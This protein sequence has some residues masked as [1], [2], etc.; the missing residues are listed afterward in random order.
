MDLN[1]LNTLDKVNGIILKFITFK[2]LE[3]KIDKE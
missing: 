3:N 1:M 2:I